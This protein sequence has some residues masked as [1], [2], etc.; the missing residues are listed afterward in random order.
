MLL[1]TMDM[2]TEKWELECSEKSYTCYLM[3]LWPYLCI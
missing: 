1:S 3:W 2:W